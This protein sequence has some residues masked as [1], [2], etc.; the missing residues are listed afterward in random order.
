MNCGPSWEAQQVQKYPEFY[1]SQISLL[2]F[3]KIAS[4]SLSLATLIQSITSYPIF[5][6][7]F[8]IVLQSVPR[9]S[10]GSLCLRLLNQNCVYISLLPHTWHVSL[11]S[12][13]SSFPYSSNI[14]WGVLIVELLI[15]QFFFL[16]DLNPLTLN[17][18]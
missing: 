10:K 14:W 15:M 13:L 2:C 16:I 7:N 1:E 5:K 8:N 12:H 17:D 18:L 6:I 9:F 3:Q 11:P 4:W